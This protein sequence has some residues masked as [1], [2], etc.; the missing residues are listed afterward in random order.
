MNKDQSIAALL[1]VLHHRIENGIYKDAVHKITLMTT[2]QT[3]ERM[4]AGK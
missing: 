4:L 3:I 1:E 2:L